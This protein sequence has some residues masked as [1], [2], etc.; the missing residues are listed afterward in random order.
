MPADFLTSAAPAA[1]PPRRALLGDATSLLLR[2]AAPEH[3]HVMIGGPLHIRK[4]V[5][6]V[7]RPAEHA[8]IGREASDCAIVR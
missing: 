2:A 1:P 6:V 8:A 5:I 4:H 7:C 3:R